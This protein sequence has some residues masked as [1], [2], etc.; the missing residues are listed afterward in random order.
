MDF[1][2]ERTTSIIAS[3]YLRLIMNDYALPFIKHVNIHIKLKTN[4]Y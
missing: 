2:A 3:K 1:I 4:Y